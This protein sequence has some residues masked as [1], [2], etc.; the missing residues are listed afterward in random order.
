MHF[1]TSTKP[2]T[3]PIVHDIPQKWTEHRSLMLV[4]YFN[5]EVEDILHTKR[6]QRTVILW[7]PARSGSIYWVHHQP[8]YC[9]V[10]EVILPA[11]K[12]FIR[13]S[14]F[15]CNC[16]LQFVNNYFHRIQKACSTIWGGTS[17]LQDRTKIWPSWLWER[18][19][20]QIICFLPLCSLLDHKIWPNWLWERRCW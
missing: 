19:E 6:D 14:S 4:L 13:K 8:L 20:L 15:T 11:S 2:T 10:G 3:S 18:R 7:H 9:I 5:L 12:L 16:L 1:A 17:W